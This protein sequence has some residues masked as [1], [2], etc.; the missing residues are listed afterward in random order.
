MSASPG[1]R[2]PGAHEPWDSGG[3]DLAAGLGVEHLIL[4]GAGGTLVLRG[5]P[6]LRCRSGTKLGGW[7]PGAQGDRARGGRRQAPGL[8]LLDPLGCRQGEGTT[9]RPDC[10]VSEPGKV[11]GAG[12]LGWGRAG[13]AG[14]RPQVV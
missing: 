8:A 4:E 12:L 2:G 14:R 7:A 11:R 13:R 1:G 9:G 3:G 6:A 10:R 5:V